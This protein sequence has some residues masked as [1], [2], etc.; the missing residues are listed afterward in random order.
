MRLKITGLKMYNLD[1]IKE[2]I[3]RKNI[4]F[5][6]REKNRKGSNGIAYRAETK[7]VQVGYLPEADSVRNK[8]KGNKEENEKL[9][10]SIDYIRLKAPQR[11]GCLITDLN[12]E[13][14][15]HPWIEVVVIPKKKEK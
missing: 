10:K 6:V 8:W 11:F 14:T 2:S 12:V 5:M 13:N 3:G 1:E 7:G 15:D 9:A 4:L